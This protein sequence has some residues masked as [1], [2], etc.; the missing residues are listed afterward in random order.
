MKVIVTG[1]AGFIGSHLAEMLR[2]QGHEVIGIDDFSTGH[3]VVEGIEQ[4]N[5]D[6]RD[7]DRIEPIFAGVDVV[8][9][10]AAMGRV[11]MCIDDPKRAYEVNVM[12]SV[13]VLE[14][15]RLNKVPRVVLSSSCIAYS[16]QDTAYKTTKIAMEEAAKAYRTF[17]GVSTVCLRYANVYGPR[18]EIGMDSAMFAML[19]DSFNREGKVHIFGDGEQ[20]RDWTYVTDIC[21]ANML[22]GLSAYE[23]EL[24]IATGR[25]ISLNYIVKDVLKVPFVHEAAR[26]GDARHIV[27]DPHPAADALGFNAEVIFENGIKNVW[28]N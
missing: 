5:E 2:D 6:I 13:N 9:H 14:A 3:N 27:L 20:T 1:S 4:Y 25:S 21:R 28:I 19:R 26:L 16:D 10:L 17:H 12:G 15:A 11:P 22:A 8:F 18:Q 23:G 24:D 7:F